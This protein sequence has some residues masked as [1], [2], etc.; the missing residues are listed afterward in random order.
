MLDDGGRVARNPAKEQG[1]R[2]VV[3]C[4]DLELLREENVYLQDDE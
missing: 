2:L 3:T 1:V 4:E